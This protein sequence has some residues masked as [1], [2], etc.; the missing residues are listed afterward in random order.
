VKLMDFLDPSEKVFARPVSKSWNKILSFTLR[1]QLRQLVNAVKGGLPLGLDGKV[2]SSVLKGPSRPLIIHTPARVLH[3]M[4]SR[5]VDFLYTTRAPSEI[6][7]QAQKL[8][9][10]GI[11]ELVLAIH[12]EEKQKV[13]DNKNLSPEVFEKVVLDILFEE[14]K[15]QLTTFNRLPMQN[16]G[17][18]NSSANVMK[19]VGEGHYHLNEALTLLNPH[20]LFY[21]Q[22]ALKHPI[23][24]YVVTNLIHIYLSLAVTKFKLK[25]FAEVTELCRTVLALEKNQID[26][27]ILAG[28][29]LVAISD[30]KEAEEYFTAARLSLN[31]L[32][33]ESSQTGTD[34]KLVKGETPKGE[35]GFYP[36][37][38]WRLKALNTGE[39]RLQEKANNWNAKL[40]KLDRFVQRQTSR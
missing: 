1:Q 24:P 29:A 35:I 37:P 30:I 17:S 5:L 18:S 20:A 6:V 26:A 28:F 19:T 36:S 16:S 27:L 12:P 23:V 14:D 2:S 31:A 25:K 4:A 15:R 3:T 10:K 38:S 22:L 21:S 9:Q 32:Q 33:K 40:Q 11:A 13:G 8:F 39:I 34:Q 7:R